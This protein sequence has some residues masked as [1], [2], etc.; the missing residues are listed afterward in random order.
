MQFVADASV[1]LSWCFEDE[2]DAWTDGLL[3]RLRSEGQII[4][5]AHW[6][7]EVSNGMLMGLRRK[8]I[9]PDRPALFW[10]ELALL[11]IEVEPPLSP[12]QAK[13]VLA[14]C[15]QYGLTVYDAAYL[16]LAKK[17]RFASAPYR[18]RPLS[19][20]PSGSNW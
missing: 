15:Q 13:T 9:Q 4:V 12:N 1:A 17:V 10:D 20:P 8:R 2:A 3:D 14:L 11:P 16:E 6:P 7:T 19:R 18:S 5:P